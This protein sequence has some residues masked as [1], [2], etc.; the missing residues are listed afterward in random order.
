MSAGQGPGTPRQGAE[1]T[2]NC[3]AKP[4]VCPGKQAKI[5]VVQRRG[6]LEGGGMWIRYRCLTCN[7]VWSLTR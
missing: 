7:G 1:V 3:R 5:T 4:D 6:L 2:M